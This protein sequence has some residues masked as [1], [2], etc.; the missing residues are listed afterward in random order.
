MPVYDEQKR[1]RDM[2]IHVQCQI[3]KTNKQA[4]KKRKKKEITGSL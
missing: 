3:K 2:Q 1:Q 4:N